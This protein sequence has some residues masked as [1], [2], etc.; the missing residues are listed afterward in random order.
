MPVAASSVI[1]AG[2]EILQAAG[3][4]GREA[5]I[6]FLCTFAASRASLYRDNPEIAESDRSRFLDRVKRRAAREPMNYIT[7]DVEFLGL[8]LSVGSGVLIPRPET[9]WWLDALIKRLRGNAFKPRSVLDL[10]AGSGCIGLALAREF[11]GAE[12]VA[13]DI[14]P[15]ALL[16]AREN[17][18]I[19]GVANISFVEGDLFGPLPPDS[20]FDLIVSNPPYIAVSELKKLEPEVRLWEPH[21]ALAGGDDG[22]D[23]YRAIF[24]DIRRFVSD[25]A[26]VAVETGSGQG[27]SVREM[28]AVAGFG[29]AKIF[30]DYAGHDRAV[31]GSI[32]EI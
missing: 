13:V 22:L 15:D 4:E 25:D 2:S 30:Y 11:P 23:F 21:V 10:C 12:V 31:F 17:A 6:L 20:S 18:A 3:I 19:N 26:V 14:S 28:M 16:Y 29:N 27:A 24:A 32:K 1:R 8:R 7:G 5:E 9:E